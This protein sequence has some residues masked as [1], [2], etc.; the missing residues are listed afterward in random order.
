[1]SVWKGDSGA[2]MDPIDIL[3]AAKLLLDEH[4]IFGEQLAWDRA[5]DLADG[6]DMEGNSVW[7]RVQDAGRFS[8]L[9]PFGIDITRTWR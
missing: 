6:Q 4:G 2:G 9:G 7:R 8:P 3:G 1:M 5:M